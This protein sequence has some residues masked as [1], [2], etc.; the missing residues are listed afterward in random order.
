MSDE[1]SNDTEVFVYSGPKGA[2]V[3]FDVVRLRVDPSITSIPALVFYE[4]KT[5]EVELCEGLVEIGEWS[6]DRCGF[7]ITKINIPNSLRIIYDRAFFDSL[8]TPICL[9]DGIESIGKAA[10]AYCIFTNFRVPPFIT[11]IP[12]CMLDTC[13]S[14]FSVEIA[15]N[16]REIQDYAFYNCNY[17]RNVAFPPNTVFG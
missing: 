5:T 16:T 6:F 3:P 10:F 4:R 13:K 17:L 12:D 2:A 8:Q 14:T 7:S 1:E 9:H 11:V 15:E